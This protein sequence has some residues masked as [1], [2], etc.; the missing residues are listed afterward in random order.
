MSASSS[1][2]YGTLR[3]T[4]ARMQPHKCVK[5]LTYW[6]LTEAGSITW[7]FLPIFPC[8]KITVSERKPTVRWKSLI[9]EGNVSMHCLLLSVS[10][11]WIWDCTASL[12]NV[13]WAR[14]ALLINP[15]PLDSFWYRNQRRNVHARKFALEFIFFSNRQQEKGGFKAERKRERETKRTKYFVSVIENKE[16]TILC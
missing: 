13:C 11:A 12:V 2:H 5:K 9:K 8:T 15:C 7:S 6:L 1:V 10:S 14:D 3:N 4:L 16:L